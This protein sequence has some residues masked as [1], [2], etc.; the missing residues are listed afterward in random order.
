MESEETGDPSL[1]PI[2]LEIS[3]SEDIAGTRLDHFVV[4]HLNSI[5]RGNVQKLIKANQITV[6]G[7]P[8]KSSHKLRLDE[9]VAITLPEVEESEE[10]DRP[11]PI[12]LE[13]LFED[14]HLAA[15]N[16]LPGMVTHPAK[17]F[18]SGTVTESISAQLNQLSDIGGPTRP[19]IVHRL[20]RDTSGVILIAKTN[21]AHEQL[22]KQF[23]D[24]TV[25]KEYM[26]I[27]GGVSDRDRD[28]IDL[29]IGPHSKIREQMAVR[30]D[31]PN[32]K[33]A[34]TFYEV[35]ERFQG[36]SLLK[37]FPKT[38]RTHQIRLHLT[39]VHHPIICDRQYAGHSTITAGELNHTD[40][41]TVVLTRMA[42]HARRISL[43][44]P[45]T[46]EPLEIEAPVPED[47]SRVLEILQGRS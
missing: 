9:R 33:P 27:V 24:R 11:P 34:Q 45:I 20:D 18:W 14:E 21:T 16:K 19:G 37:A 28:M 25:E 17:G 13:V 39:H 2:P 46:Q 43:V 38:G 35:V 4:S 30:R 40:D 12:V 26:A 47:M 32:A 15:V 23:K 41:D 1:E 36:F 8:A 6:N 5:S 29:P 7:E 22:A 42:L 10:E 3:I 31:D 44:H